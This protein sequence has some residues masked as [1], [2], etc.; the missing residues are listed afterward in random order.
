MNSSPPA[1]EIHDLT[2]QY[3]HKP[4]LWGIDLEVPTGSLAA[5]VGPNGAGKSTL[6]KAAL[7]LIPRASGY[8]KFFGGSIE[9]ATSRIAYVPQ[10]EEVDW[11]FPITVEDVVMMGCYGDLPFWKFE[12]TKE[13]ERVDSALARVEMLDYRKRLIRELSGGQQQR[14]FL[15]RALAQEADL[16]LLDE[17]FSGIDAATET[18]LLEVFSELKDSGKTVICIHHDLHTVFE[19]FTYA[20]LLNVRLIQAG[21]IQEV[22]QEEHLRKAYG[23]NLN[24]LSS[25]IEKMRAVHWTKRETSR[26]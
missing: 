9:Q 7:E 25:L 2:V 26:E 23:G 5:V 18:K 15:A 24:V 13:R 22:F 4:V 6:L 12:S 8:A 21:T 11:D 3:Q 14:V 19:E 16:F 10:R 17:P 20:A 1:F